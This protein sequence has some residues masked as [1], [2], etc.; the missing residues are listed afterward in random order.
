MEGQEEEVVVV[1]RS[2]EFKKNRRS[3]EMKEKSEKSVR[4]A[5]DTKLR[6]SSDLDVKESSEEGDTVSS[7]RKI[8]GQDSEKELSILLSI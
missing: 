4:F 3:S 8:R 1:R 5:P 2:S 7:F 6:I